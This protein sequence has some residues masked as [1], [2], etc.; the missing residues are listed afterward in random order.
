MHDMKRTL[1]HGH[2]QSKS[3]NA[4]STINSFATRCEPQQGA[5][6]DWF[7]IQTEDLPQSVLSTPLNT[8]GPHQAC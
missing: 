2:Q 3:G 5:N 4:S 6:W 1:V 7:E 8:T